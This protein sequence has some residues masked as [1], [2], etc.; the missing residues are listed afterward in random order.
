MKKFLVFLLAAVGVMAASSPDVGLRPATSWAAAH[1]M[2]QTSASGVL[3]ELGLLGGTVKD[4]KLG[5]GA[6]GDGTTDD[7]AAIVAAFAAANS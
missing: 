3:T 6:K 7:T 4:V 5:Y 1:L 2:N